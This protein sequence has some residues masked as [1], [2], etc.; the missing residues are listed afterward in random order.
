MLRTECNKD[1]RQGDNDQKPWNTMTYPCFLHRYCWISRTRLEIMGIAHHLNC[2]W[3]NDVLQGVVWEVSTRRIDYVVASN[4]AKKEGASLE[5]W[6]HANSSIWANFI[7][8][9]TSCD[10]L[11]IA[12]LEDDWSIENTVETIIQSFAWYMAVDDGSIDAQLELWSSAYQTRIER[13]TRTL[14]WMKQQS[15]WKRRWNQAPRWI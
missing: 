8:N 12:T 11:R 10:L 13:L 14:R 2:C 7:S 3:I 4:A 6:N 9:E 1:H 15:C 5:R